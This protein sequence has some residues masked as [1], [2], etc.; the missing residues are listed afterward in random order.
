MNITKNQLAIFKRHFN[1]ND[2]CGNEELE[3][4]RYIHR[5]KLLNQLLIGFK[6]NE[7]STEM[8]FKDNKLIVGG[9]FINLSEDESKMVAEFIE[10][11]KEFIEETFA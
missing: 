4:L 2:K 6:L 10:T 1:L 9:N 3:S 11:N 7:G 8:G 5:S